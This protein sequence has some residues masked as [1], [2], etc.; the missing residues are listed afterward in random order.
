MIQKTFN[1]NSRIYFKI[2]KKM[3]LN[4]RRPWYK[5]F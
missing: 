2:F 5:R 3:D 1:K 4:L